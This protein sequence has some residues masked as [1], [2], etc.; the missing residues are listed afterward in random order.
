MA[1]HFGPFDDS[2]ERPAAKRLRVRNG[3][4]AGLVR[5]AGARP[6]ANRDDEVR[7]SSSRLKRLDLPAPS[8]PAAKGA[9]AP[10]AGRCGQGAPELI[11]GKG[12]N[13]HPCAPRLANMCDLAVDVAR[14][15]TPARDVR[16][17]QPGAHH[18]RRVSGRIAG[19]VVTGG[20]IPRR[21][22]DRAPRGD[23]RSELEDGANVFV[24]MG[25]GWRATRH[26]ERCAASGFAGQFISASGTSR[27]AMRAGGSNERSTLVGGGCR[28][29][30][31]E[32]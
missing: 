4:A 3:I 32:L 23:V 9:V 30:E 11:V 19:R 24:R 7:T 1:V 15:S 29:R 5:A 13:R 28:D 10:R 25:L 22:A 26:G 12:R 8:G 2:P 20:A 17:P 16:P 27:P 18:R 6:C 14:R 21:A 31:D